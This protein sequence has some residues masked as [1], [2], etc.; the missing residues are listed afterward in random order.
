MERHPDGAPARAIL[1]VVDVASLLDMFRHATTPLVRT[2]FTDDTTWTHIVASVTAPLDFEDDLPESG[3]YAPNITP[4][5]DKNFQGLDGEALAGA[6]DD[7]LGGYV[8]LADST[9]MSSPEDLTVVYV[10][11]YDEPG[12]TF[13]CAAVEIAS[14]EANLS[15]ANMAFEEFADS[16][17]E[18]GIFRDFDD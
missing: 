7:D 16:V 15:I 8:L 11:M 4:V 18:D 17:G 5:D 1:T 3:D 13:R 9:S 2:D 6:Y 10:D 14:I 12:R